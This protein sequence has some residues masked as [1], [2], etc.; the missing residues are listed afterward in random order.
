MVSVGEIKN[1]SQLKSYAGLPT[2]ILYSDFSD[3]YLS[4]ETHKMHLL[5]HVTHMMWTYVHYRKYTK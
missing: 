5:L 4:H 1:V 3:I 2:E